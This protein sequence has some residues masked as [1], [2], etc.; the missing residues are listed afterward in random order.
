MAAIRT[1]ELARLA[2]ANGFTSIECHRA[3]LDGAARLLRAL[4]TGQYGAPVEMRAIFEDMSRALDEIQV[5]VS[6]VDV[7]L[8]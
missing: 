6:F 4:S 1:A 2:E 5:K 3:M 7:G 8:K